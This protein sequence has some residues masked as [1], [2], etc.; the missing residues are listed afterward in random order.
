MRV[1]I[2][3]SGDRGDYRVMV[4]HARQAQRIRTEY[5]L[6]TSVAIA[7]VVLCH[8]LEGFFEHFPQLDSFI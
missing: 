8:Y 7:K 5:L 1:R 3:P 2:R 4:A 6:L